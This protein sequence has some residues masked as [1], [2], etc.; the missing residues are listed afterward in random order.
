MFFGF[1][2][3]RTFPNGGP[4]NAKISQK[5]KFLRVQQLQKTQ[6]LLCILEVF[7]QEVCAESLDLR[8]W[9]SLVFRFKAWAES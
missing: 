5:K 2:K 1:V 7:V 3:K 8:L 6:I 9:R 4:Q